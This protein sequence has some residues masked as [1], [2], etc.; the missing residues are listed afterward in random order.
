[1]ALADDAGSPER[2]SAWEPK[3]YVSDPGTAAWDKEY[4]ER[5]EKESAEL[6]ESIRNMDADMKAQPAR[7]QADEYASLRDIG[8]PDV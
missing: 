2:L 3:P 7:W 5:R 1:M 6:Q 8:W 4:A